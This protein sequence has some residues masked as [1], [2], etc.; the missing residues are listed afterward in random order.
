M[1]QTKKVVQV[2]THEQASEIF[3]AYN[4]S[5]S[6]LKI[7]EGEM[8]AE[9]TAIDEKYSARIGALQ[10]ERDEKFEQ[11]QVYAEANPDL[12]TKKKSY[13]LTHGTI[14]FRTGTPKLSLLKGFKWDAV[15]AL[16]KKV[17]P[18]Y[19][20]VAESVDKDGML[21]DRAKLGDKLAAVGV[22]VKQ[23]ET[24]FVQP[25]LQEIATT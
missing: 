15:L 17:L 8:S 9:K 25:N 1:R 24:F 22:E 3:A 6:G 11:L 4:N 10:K 5:I 14:G 7:I 2:P 23:D 19:V 18:T 20:R 16:A 12:F 21:A 13:E